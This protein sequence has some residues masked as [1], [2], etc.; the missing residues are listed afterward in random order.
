MKLLKRRK[1]E[2]N[3]QNLMDTIKAGSH[4][5]FFGQSAQL[6]AAGGEGIIAGVLLL[7]PTSNKSLKVA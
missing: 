3:V 1:T 6:R 2:I 5:P 4:Y 7:G